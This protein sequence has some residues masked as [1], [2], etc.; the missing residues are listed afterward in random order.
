MDSLT[1]IH[2]NSSQNKNNRKPQTVLLPDLSFLKCNKNF[3]NSVISA[4]QKFRDIWGS[5]KTNLETHFLNLENQRFEYV[6]FS[7]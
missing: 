4:P 2:H 7:Q 3:E 5:P 1:L 6:T